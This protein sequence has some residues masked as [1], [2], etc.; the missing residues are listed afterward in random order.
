MLEKD[1][2]VLVVL[3]KEAK[4]Y[5]ETYPL[6]SNESELAHVELEDIVNHYSQVSED[7]TYDMLSNFARFQALDDVL[8]VLKISV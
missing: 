5:V 4:S 8:K 6:V 7:A 1:K 3:W 2:Q